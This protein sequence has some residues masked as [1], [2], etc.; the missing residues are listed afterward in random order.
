VIS[1]RSLLKVGLWS[2]ASSQLGCWPESRTG[3]SAA[4]TS[5]EAPKNCLFIVLDAAAARHF[6]S[7]GYGRE[8]TPN[9][10]KLAD[11]GFIFRNAFSQAAET[12]P[13]VRSYLTGQYPQDIRIRISDSEFTLADAFQQNGFKTALF[14]ENPYITPTFNYNKGFEVNSSYY[15]FAAFS[16]TKRDRTD[17]KLESEKLHGD[18]RDWISSARDSPWFCY[19]HHLRP[20]APYLSPEPFATK[21]SKGLSRGRADGSAYTVRTLEASATSK[22]AAYLAALYDGNLSYSDAL[23]ARLIE[24]L[25]STHRLDDTLVILA[26]DHGEAFMQHGWLQHGTTTYDE[27]IHV[28]L[29]LKFPA[30][31]GLGRGKSFAQ[32]EMLDLFPTLASAFG[33][34]GIP[35]LDGRSLLP[36]VLG[37]TEVH[38]DHVFTFAPKNHHKSFAVRTPKQKYIINLDPAEKQ[39]E[40]RELYD[41]DADHLEGENLLAKDAVHADFEA[42]LTAR[43]PRYLASASSAVDPK[44]DPEKLDKRTRDALEALGYIRE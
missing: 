35:A 18:V 37:E 24:W 34:S 26:A 28:P 40:S 17:V 32:V 29:I 31:S 44:M 13:S 38:K 10:A 41:L 36:L 4:G 20:H 23:V 15:T 22:E 39:V 19:I 11:T 14:S 9:I 1:R 25:E 42:L 8:T 33:L 3:V 12:V 16:R 43:Y 21:F 7:W 27:M 5:F 2:L 6:Q 30:G